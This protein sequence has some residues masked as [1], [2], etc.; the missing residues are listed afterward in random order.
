MTHPPENVK[1]MARAIARLKT[2]NA[3]MKM[4]SFFITSHNL[5]NMKTDVNIIL[6]DIEVFYDRSRVC[7]SS[8]EPLSPVFVRD[9]S[10]D[11][12]SPVSNNV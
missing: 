1:D 7:V 5:A 9:S 2:D 10:Q 8:K 11:L 4:K 6:V 12:P 3:M